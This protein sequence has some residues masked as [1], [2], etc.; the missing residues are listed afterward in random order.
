MV[1]VSF[2]LLVACIVGEAIHALAAVP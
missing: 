2:F 1:T